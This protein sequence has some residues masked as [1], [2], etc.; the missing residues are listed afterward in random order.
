MSLNEPKAGEGRAVPMAYARV[1]AK[2]VWFR[3]WVG[4]LVIGLI[5]A[6]LLGQV[7]RLAYIHHVL[8][9]SLLEYSE[10]RQTS[11]VALPARRGA[12]LD[13]RF[14]VLAGSHDSPTVYADPRMVK[15]HTEAAQEL[16]R[17]LGKPS[18]EILQLLRD[19]KKRAFVV[20]QR[21]V[22]E[23]EAEGV[24]DLKI[25]GV[26]VRN[27]PSRTYP[28]GTL[29]AHVVGFVRAGKEGPEGIE[30]IELA[31][32]KYLR[33][34][35]GQREVYRDVK[36]RA[37]FEKPDSYQAPKDGIHVVLSLDS[38]IQ[39]VLESQLAA[40]VAKFRAESAI[41]VVMSPKNGDVYA[42]A[43]YPAFDP[44]KVA[45]VPRDSRILCNR[46][47][48]DPVEPGSV[49]KPFVL[50]EVLS[51]S[52]ARPA[53]TVFCHNGLYETGKRRL[54]DHHPYGSLTV[55]QILTKSSNIGMAILGQRLGN[56][57][58]HAG[59]SRFGFG[60]KTGVDLPGEDPGL[61]LPV[62]RW[63]SFST[64]SIPMG[65]EIAITPM[66]LATAFCSLVNGGRLLMPR[67]V[68]A[69]LDHDGNVFEDR[70]A[71]QGR[72]QALNP[73]TA[74]VMK[75]LLAKVVNEGTGKPAQLVQWQVM[76]KTGT[77]QIPKFGHKGYEPNA[78]LASF[79]AAAPETDPAVVVLITVR[80]PDR[81]I[82]Y[83]G[84]TV[85]APPVKAVL[86][87]VLPYLGIPPER[88]EE[89]GA[90]LKVGIVGGGD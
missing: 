16:A 61:M 84:G 13:C 36:R 47:L 75:S 90:K 81:S 77:A 69:V 14:R 51:E 68:S 11:T 87:M 8:R 27:E 56:P 40:T 33:G 7:G 24:R 29:A 49:F 4:Q 73:A 2:P 60:R 31:M 9:P 57:R 26:G 19:P 28:M 38:A 35:S 71:A 65:Q 32:D 50:A 1:Q 41:G 6:V 70:T 37:I 55:E 12:I 66:Q 43:C 64:T 17:V 78:Y 34:K 63:N 22:A 21:G 20:I 72:G 80:K 59:L 74:A 10:R 15:N 48:T 53:E 23:N 83:Y 46:V 67:V 44:G 39:E 18:E 52:A 30:G 82:G 54:H 58:M 45:Q 42:M 89:E 5:C 88:S 85:S 79:I 76:G 3:P 62:K 25:E 86:E